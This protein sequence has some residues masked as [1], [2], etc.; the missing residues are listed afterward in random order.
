M[1]HSLLALKAAV[2]VAWTR[3]ARTLELGVRLIGDS[4]GWRQSGGR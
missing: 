2:T 3:G 1:L 4:H